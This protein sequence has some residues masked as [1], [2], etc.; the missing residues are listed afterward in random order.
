[1]ISFLVVLAMVLGGFVGAQ[2]AQSGDDSSTTDSTEVPSTVVD[3]AETSGNEKPI[4]PTGDAPGSSDEPV[5]TAPSSN[6]AEPA[7]NVAE[8]LKKIQP[9][10]V[11]II[12]LTESG[13]DQG[14][15]TGTGVVITSDGDI[16]TNDHVIDGADTVF[17]LF[18]GDTEPTPATVIAVDPG[19]D[20]A[21]LHVDQTGLTPAVFADPESIDIGDE[22]VAVG[23]ALDLDG[24]PTVTRG[25]V[26]ALN[27]T[28]V[29]GDGA[30]D[31]LIQTDTAISSGNSGG[32]LVNTRGQ[33]I[34]INTAVF[35][36]SSEV[37][38][39]NVGFSISVAE[40]LPVIEEL[41]AQANGQARTEGYLGVS[42][43][44]RNDGGLGAVI[45]EVS[46]GSPADLAGM[47]VND[48]V[49]EADGSPVDGQPALVA[50]IRDKS[51][52]DSIKIDVLR[53]GERIT[54]T[55]TLIERPTQ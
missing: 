19:N 38:A 1:V 50:A 30:L 53:D 22:V 21:L 20:L 35:Q 24:G 47:E 39:N 2:I 18:A 34:G 17:V 43:L 11:T 48:V 29:S 15:G 40:A 13:M 3:E 33:V 54:L 41:R 27:R 14:R 37:A 51:P 52:G 45:A 10:V 7:M 12:A 42:V 4:V 23:F 31:G 6:D 16:L 49:I 9:S 36:S 55:A 28:I 5:A 44:D 8:V 46:L 26:S 25:I 32:P